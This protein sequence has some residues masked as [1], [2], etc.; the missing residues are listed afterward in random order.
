MRFSYLIAFAVAAAVA[1]WIL[2]GDFGSQLFGSDPSADA[3]GPVLADRVQA[4]EMDDELEPFSVRVFT[5][6]ATIRPRVIT[7]RGHTEASRVVVVRAE[8]PGTIERI[9][10]SKGDRVVAGQVIA[11][12]ELGDRPSRLAEVEALLAQRQLEFDIAR[13]LAAQ[14][15]QPVTRVAAAQ[16]AF[17]NAAGIL[18]RLELDIEKTEIKAPFAG[19]IEE[20]QVQIGD[21]ISPG[22]PAATLVD[23]DPFLVV[24][25]VS[26]TDIDQIEL[27][28][29][30]TARLLNGAEVAGTVTF[31]ATVADPQTRTFRVELQVANPGR[32]MRAEVTADFSIPVGTVAAHLVSPAVLVLDENGNLGVKLVN[33]GVVEQFPVTIL[34]SGDGGIWLLGLPQT[35]TIITVGQQ[36]VTEGQVV[37]PVEGGAP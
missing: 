8:T 12:L 31:I 3:P 37:T 28:T 20:R 9:L 16:T 7:V 26:E 1:A 18:A 14:G 29:A 30:A 2:S 15:Q 35:A 23:E 4:A 10:V 22:T 5:Q 27:G 24:G 21:F 17:E 6:T 19:V 11:T 25:Q 36:F 13:S 33:L 32:T 34:S